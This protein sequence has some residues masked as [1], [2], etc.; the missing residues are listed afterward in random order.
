MKAS[1]SCQKGFLGLLSFRAGPSFSSW[2]RS[3]HL[4]LEIHYVAH[5]LTR[6]FVMSSPQPITRNLFLYNGSCVDK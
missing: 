1:V 5:I 3:N 2:A 4:L 6:P